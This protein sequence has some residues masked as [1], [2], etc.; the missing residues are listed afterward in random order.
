[1]FGPSG[2]S[3]CQSILCSA[4]KNNIPPNQT[5]N[6]KSLVIYVE[7]VSKL[8]VYIFSSKKNRRKIPADAVPFG[9]EYQWPP[10]FFR[11]MLRPLTGYQPPQGGSPTDGNQNEDRASHISN[12]SFSPSLTYFFLSHL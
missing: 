3:P 7:G 4:R 1:M 2:V 10:G 9:G 8:F 11:V 6:I 12:F 5:V